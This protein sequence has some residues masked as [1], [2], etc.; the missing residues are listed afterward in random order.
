MT[1]TVVFVREGDGRYAVHVPAL[2][3]CHTQVDSLPHAILMAE[4]VIGLYVES[5]QDRGKSMP[6]DV[7]TLTL[8]LGD[9]T[10]AVVYRLAVKEG[11]VAA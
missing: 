3:G 10:E 9:A 7:D 8:D 2:K 6:V 11:V 4:E 1:Y 5:L